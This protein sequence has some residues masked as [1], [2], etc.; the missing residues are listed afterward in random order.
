V[1]EEAVTLD[2]MA[3]DPEVTIFFQFGICFYY[4]W[5]LELSNPLPLRAYNVINKY[6]YFGFLPRE[7]L[8]SLPVNSSNC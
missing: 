2:K 5:L 7:E 8:I 3:A 6:Y 4:G 1:N